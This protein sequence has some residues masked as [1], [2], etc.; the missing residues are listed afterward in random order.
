MSAPTARRSNLFGSW[1]LRAK[2]LVAF[3][4]VTAL[5]VF[6]GGVGVWGS[7]TQSSASAKQSAVVPILHLAMQAKYQT[8]DF[9]GFQTAA[10]YEIARGVTGALSDK[11]PNRAAFLD[12]YG[13]FEAQLAQLRA[14]S[15]TGPERLQVQKAEAGLA[16]FKKLDG[17]GMALFQAGGTRTSTKR[18]RSSST[19]RSLRMSR[20]EARWTRSSP[21]YARAAM[22]LRSSRR[23]LARSWRR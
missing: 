12:S 16:D 4:T 15:L 2:L 22:R 10:A 1:S 13:K 23:P 11:A 19:A 14:A 7:R 9:F 3:G 17:Q 5:L 18:R 6:V 21:P 20:S 8:A